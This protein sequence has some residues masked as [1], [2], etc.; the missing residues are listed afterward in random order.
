M[1]T[2]QNT[3]LNIVLFENLKLGLTKC[4]CLKRHGLFTALLIYTCSM[5]HESLCVRLLYNI[6]SLESCMSFGLHAI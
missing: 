6:L 5:N 1:R 3:A 4:K 2:R